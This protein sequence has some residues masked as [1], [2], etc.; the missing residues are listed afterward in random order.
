MALAILLPSTIIADPIPEPVKNSPAKAHE[1]AFQ[2]SVRSF[3]EDAYENARLHSPFASFNAA[4][5][6]AVDASPLASKILNYANKFLGT[7]Y[8]LGAA[9]PKAFDCS[10]FTSYVFR[11]AGGVE[12]ERSSRQQYTQGERVSVGSLRPGDLL[13][14]SSASSGRGNVGHVAIV[15]SVDPENNTC[16]FIH[17]STKRGVTY[18]TFPDNGYYSRHFI[19]AKRVIE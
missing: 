8:R 4:E 6:A 2:E 5:K 10:G 18:Q 17:A 15:E 11:N 16:R 9:G 3:V 14:F 7:R 19:G 1:Q 13:F 12:L